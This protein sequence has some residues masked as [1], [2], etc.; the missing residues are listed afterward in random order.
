MDTHTT[1]APEEAAASSS[2]ALPLTLGV[3]EE[4]LLVDA[5][6]RRPAPVAPEVLSVLGGTSPRIQAEGT[7]YQV[8]LAT[9]VAATATALRASL[10]SLRAELA[11]AA[12]Q[13]GCRLVASPVPVLGPPGAVEL[14]RNLARHRAIHRH[15]GELAQTL[16]GCGR[17]VHVGPLN[18]AGAVG[19]SNRIRPWT[20]TLIA[21]SANSPYAYGR[22]S[23]HASWRTTAWSGW[24]SAGPAPY[25]DGPAG[26]E[27]TVRRFLDSGAVL[28]PHMLYWDVR[29]SRN[30]PTV[31]L[32]APDVSPCAD[33]A[34]LLAVLGR[35][36][37]ATALR[38][39]EERLPLPAVEDEVLRLARWRAAHDGL[40]GRALDPFTGAEVPAARLVVRLLES[41]EPAL[42]GAG[43]LEFA[44]EAVDA[45][46]REGSW[47]A[48]Q[49]R[50]FTRGGG[51]AA[52]VDF[53]AE[54]TER[55]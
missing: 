22:D 6:T 5:V 4:F 14:T 43:D 7:P 26:Y 33:H 16:I 31:E 29:P 9:E 37:A 53:L 24:P 10:G 19:V 3:E 21:L 32:R 28:D 54:E 35:A 18:T 13:V 48:R 20:A 17:H 25:F 47:A 44:A 12:R 55:G 49:R 39:D 52:V 50:V 8:E 41:L 34:V 1:E 23:G 45:L 30:W 11:A 2:P 38:A 40:E 46:L 36:L 15:F 27:R 51:A 42:A